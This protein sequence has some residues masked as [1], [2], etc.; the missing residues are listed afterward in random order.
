MKILSSCEN[1]VFISVKM[2]FNEDQI[3]QYLISLE[4]SF[5]LELSTEA[6]TGCVL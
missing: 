5:K 4:A 6:V 1:V 2:K 3:A